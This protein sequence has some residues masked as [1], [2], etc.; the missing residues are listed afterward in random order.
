MGQYQ[1]PY[2]KSY[3]EFSLPGG[4]VDVISPITHP[5]APDGNTITRAALERAFLF[6]EVD[7]W[8][9]YKSASVAINDKTRPVPYDV[10]L[11][12]LIDQLNR[13][14][15]EDQKITLY[16]ATGTHAP[17]ED[18]E[19][20]LIVP[21]SIRNRIRVVPHNCDDQENLRFLGMTSRQTP[22]YVNQK[23]ISADLRIVTGNI[24][25]HHFMGFS[26]GAKTASIGLAGRTTINKNHAMLLD[27]NAKMGIYERNPMRQDVEEIGDMMRIQVAVNTILNADKKI[28]QV[29][30]GS[31]RSVMQTG[32]PL[33]R[34]IS[35]IRIPQK[36]D[37]VIA[38]AGGHPKDINLYQAQKA[39][40]HAAEF[41]QPGAPILL[42]AE[43]PDGSGSAGFEDFIVTCTHLEDVIQKFH[44][45]GFQVGPHKALQ[46]AVQC[47]R[48]PIFLLSNLDEILARRFFLT[49]V[50]SIDQ[51]ISLALQALPT[52]PRI[53][54]LPHATGT[55]AFSEIDR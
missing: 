7:D 5:P 45:Q 41:A 13:I 38:S 3:I 15:I 39:I 25:P 43:C 28:I 44:R 53:V 4:K 31:P 23:F 48:N 33:S 12:A 34:Q 24:E 20:K 35:Q 47:Q 46:L 54:V 26:G 19:I 8:S 29:V 42:A 14:G 1:I 55:I 36:Y 30:A 27:P 50:K 52:A 32:I 18:N 49:P 37:M 21:S 2:G 16:I 51:G 10:I 40:T 22:V 6:N 9:N 11:P 17:A